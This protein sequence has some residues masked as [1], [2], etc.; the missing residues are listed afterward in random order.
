MI[1]YT[2]EARESWKKTAWELYAK[3]GKIKGDDL[4]YIDA[5]HLETIIELF[6]KYVDKEA[7]ESK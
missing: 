2:D 4:S 1:L 5:K 7:R 6:V 3:I